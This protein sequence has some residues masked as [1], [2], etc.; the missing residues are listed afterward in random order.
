MKYNILYLPTRYF[1][2]ISGAEFYLQRMAEILTRDYDYN[3]DIFTSN[4]IDFRA[5]RDPKGKTINVN[6]IYYNNVNNLE[7]NRTS[8]N[9]NISDE[10][11]LK[12]L[13]QFDEFKSL[14]LSDDLLME[15]FNNGPYLP[16][17]IDFFLNSSKKKYHLIHT[18]FFPYFNLVISLLIGKKLNIPVI[19][20]PFYHF[21]NPRY[22]NSIISGLLRKFDLIIAC[23]NKEKEVLTKEL[24]I[25]GEKI[26]VIPM[27][28]D[29]EKF[30][31]SKAAKKNIYSFKANYF[32]KKEKNHKMVLFCG[33]KNY[34]KGAL[35]LLN[36]IPSILEKKRKT[37]FVF[38]GPATMAYNRE[39]SKI[40]K[41]TPARIINLTP[42]NLNGYYD[43][44]K[45]SA[46]KETDIFVMPSRSDAFGI[47][48]L[49]AWASGKPVIGAD[50]GAISE[51]IM[52]N[53]DGLLVEFDNPLELAKKIIYLLKNKSIRKRF[54][55][56][57]REKV[58]N[59]FTWTI[60]AKRT[61]EIYQDIINNK[62]K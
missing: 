15:I 49:E 5:L 23:T 6:D 20:T 43:K 61:H 8:I 54:G 56:T 47:A 37:N 22:I 30:M 7:I 38:I 29:Y 50:I 17:L 26:V 35:S 57:G 55:T 27:G 18:T 36:A 62:L 31:V 10:D 33:Y 9:Y 14:K 32:N 25:Q 1:P 16:N 39:L 3:I 2:S 45:I 59:K 34:E 52:N 46:F 4:A 13:K 24:G 53:E 40:K 11:K 60:I 41:H 44:K 12:Y 28:V 21:S 48:F 19:V 51:V 42:D 58:K